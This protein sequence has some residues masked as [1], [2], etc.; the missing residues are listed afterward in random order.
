M[1]KA[2]IEV[3]INTLKNNIKKIN[4]LT[5]E[6]ERKIID[7]RNNCYGLGIFLVNTFFDMGFKYGYVSNLDEALKVRKY[8]SK[9]NII[10]KNMVIGDNVFDAINNNIILTITDLNYLQDISLI[11][12]KDVIKLHLL[13]D[14]GANNIGLKSYE[15]VKK[16]IEIINSKKHLIL[17]GI[18]TDIT[19]TGYIDEYYYE[20]MNN[21]WKIMENIQNQNILVYANEYIMY[22]EK[23]EIFNSIMLDLSVY[24]LN[25]INEIDNLKRKKIQ[26]KYGR[27]AFQNIDIDL[28]IPFSIVGYITSINYVLSK[29]LIGRNYYNKENQRIGFVNIGYKDGLTK[30][31]KVVVVNNKI[32]NILTDNIDSM[33]ISI[34][35]DVKI[36][37]KVY[38]ISE[39]NNMQNVLVNLKTN[40]YYLMSIINNNLPRIYILNDE[41][42]E[43]EYSSI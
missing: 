36:G 40:R 18:Y 29:N 15:E 20:Q 27:Y 23:Q 34:D 2:C 9:I 8:N 28:N 35:D 3:N 12:T 21:F 24:G 14:N 7:L 31:L 25:P 11:K 17:D 5:E 30:A 32:S 43:Q 41:K 4:K 10:V 16:A 33:I 26:K 19:T 42:I 13:I 39:Y 6:Y 1:N 22:H 37:D 38:L